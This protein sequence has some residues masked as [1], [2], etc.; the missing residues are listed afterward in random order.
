MS[1]TVDGVALMTVLA[2]AVLLAAAEGTKAKDDDLAV[3]K[4]AVAHPTPSV[5]AQNQAVSPAVRAQA[6]PRPA[7]A[8]RA[9]RDHEPQWFKVRVVDKATGKK[10]VTVNLPL[11]VVRALGDD[12][13][14]DWPCGGMDA[15]VR[16]TVRLSEVLSALEA[17]Q[18]L[19]QVD[20]DDSEVRVWVE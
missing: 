10:K 17:G 19:V 14:I 16:S 1:L 13:P 15:R 11:S 8:P 7:P 12:M 3:V 6:E 2:G 9:A 18:D 5:V 4:R 20:D